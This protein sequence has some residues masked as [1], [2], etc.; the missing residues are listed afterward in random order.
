[1]KPSIFFVLLS[2]FSSLSR[3]QAQQPAIPLPA[4]TL[5]QH[6]LLPIGYNTTTVLV[7][8][9]PVKPIDRGNRDIIAQKQPGAENVLKIKAAR[10]NFP[11]TNLHVFTE[12]GKIF[13]FDVIYTDS[14]ASTYNLSTLNFQVSPN[15][16]SIILLSNEPVNTADMQAFVDHVKNLPASHHGP[17]DNRDKMSIRLDDV[18]I[19]GPIMFFRFHIANHSNIEYNMNFL[20]LYIRDRIKSKRT[21]VQQKEILPVYEDDN[22]TIP[23]NSSITHVIAVPAFTLAGGKQF[24]VESYEKNGGRSLTLFVKNKTMLKARKL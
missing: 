5:I 1:M 23:G 13:A 2:F 21:S 24:I 4:G 8:A 22:T 3:I 19:A 18:S 7:F 12:D 17:I 20:R 9:A 6:Y 10:K 11:I 15:S 16:Q 14:L